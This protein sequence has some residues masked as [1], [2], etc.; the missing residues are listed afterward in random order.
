[1]TMEGKIEGQMVP[2]NF[3]L[4]RL[5]EKYKASAILK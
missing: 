1:M 2:S 3:K 4:R 5:I